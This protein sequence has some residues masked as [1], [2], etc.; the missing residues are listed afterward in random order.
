M[1]QLGSDQ[2]GAIA[3]AA[4]FMAVLL[5]GAACYLMGIGDSLL[6]RERLQDAADAVAF[7]SAVLHARGMNLLAL[8]N[9]TMAALL[10]ILVALK[11]VEL[12]MTIALIAI[13]I[14]SYYA[15]GLASAIPTIAELRAN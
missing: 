1:R 2:R 5:T 15:P 7:S 12:L 4:L 14:A 9:M 6:Q 8:L 13:M 11:L 10:A 3:F